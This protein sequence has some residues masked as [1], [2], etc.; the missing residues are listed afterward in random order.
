MTER[1]TRERLSRLES[2]C[3]DMYRE[4]CA[5]GRDDVF[6]FDYFQSEAQSLGICDDAGERPA[7]VKTAPD[8]KRRI[9][10]AELFT[11]E[12]ADG[13][14]VTLCADELKAAGVA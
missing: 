12:H 3:R 13:Q 1:E 10:V 4:L 5:I 7:F 6:L 2:L 14:R 9:S 8:G 11:F